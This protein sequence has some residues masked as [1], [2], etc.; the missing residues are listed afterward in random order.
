MDEIERERLLAAL[1]DQVFAE[2]MR[3]RFRE[4]DEVDAESLRI[5]SASTVLQ[6]DP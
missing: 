2:E 4:L 6:S 1:D 3:A 5:R